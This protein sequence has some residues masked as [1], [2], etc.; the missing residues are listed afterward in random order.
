MSSVLKISVGVVLNDNACS[1]NESLHSVFSQT[2]LRK[3]GRYKYEIELIAVAGNDA[4]KNS[5]QSAFDRTQIEFPAGGP[6]QLRIEPS[7]GGGAATEW[8]Q[9][10]SFFRADADFIFIVRNGATLTDENVFEQML[11]TIRKDY[12]MKLLTASGVCDTVV[13]AGDCICVRGAALREI[14]IPENFPGG[15]ETCF[16]RLMMSDMAARPVTPARIGTLD[17]SVYSVQRCRT[18]GELFRRRVGE[19]IEETVTDILIRH[20][21]ETRLAQKDLDIGDYIRVRDTADPSWIFRLVQLEIRAGG[22]RRS[23]PPL[24]ACFRFLSDY[25]ISAWKKTIR[26]PRAVICFFI[27]IPAHV[28]AV[29]CLKTGT[30]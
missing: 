29:R 24:R 9:L 13:V 15:I 21:R 3:A 30:F 12:D 28:A 17:E 25:K 27:D 5:A 8:N 23:M 16:R 22:L 11:K 6:V 1:V 4:V 20:L 26:L 2:A 10:I 7:T 19:L 18:D 14:R